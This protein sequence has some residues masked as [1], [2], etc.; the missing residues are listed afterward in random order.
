MNDIVPEEPSS[1]IAS[2]NRAKG[3]VVSPERHGYDF[4]TEYKRIGGQ[5]EHSIRQTVSAYT[6]VLTKAAGLEGPTKIEYLPSGLKVRI[7]DGSVLGIIK[8]S[9][10]VSDLRFGTEFQGLSRIHP[11]G[12]QECYS[13]S[14]PSK[15]TDLPRTYFI[16]NPGGRE[17]TINVFPNPFTAPRDPKSSGYIPPDMR[18]VELISGAHFSEAPTTSTEVS[19]EI[20]YYFK[21]PLYQAQLDLRRSTTTEISEG[22]FITSAV[23]WTTEQT[24][25]QKLEGAWIIIHTFPY[26]LE[27]IGKKDVSSVVPLFAHEGEI[28]YLLF[29]QT[30]P[31]SEKALK[32]AFQHGNI[33]PF[34]PDRLKEKLHRLQLSPE[35]AAGLHKLILN[36]IE[37]DEDS[38]K[39]RGLSGE[40]KSTPFDNGVRV[41]QHA[42]KLILSL[43]SRSTSDLL[44]GVENITDRKLPSSTNK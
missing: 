34:T 15:I 43:L 17:Q 4:L 27:M 41:Y 22:I 3:T 1:Q 8:K 20:E 35:D 39:V 31:L 21:E 23:N 29:D 18:I 10:R 14:D 11:D 5:L 12:I 40:T 36:S 2:F 6:N 24:S 13:I 16:V 7:A 37:V 38:L 9:D 30:K 42:A 32:L 25:P 44:S 28:L 33:T 19:Q 26:E